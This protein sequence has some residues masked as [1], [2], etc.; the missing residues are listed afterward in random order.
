MKYE[1][2]RYKCDVS[3]HLVN[4]DVIEHELEYLVRAHDRVNKG[5][6]TV[7]NKVVAEKR[8]KLMIQGGETIM[9]EENFEVE[10]RPHQ[11]V[12]TAWKK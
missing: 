4:S 9:V 7:S 12:V 10:D 5:Q 8:E 1:C 2:T 11:V 6:N 3:F